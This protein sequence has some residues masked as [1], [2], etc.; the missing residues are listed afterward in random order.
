VFG[1]DYPTPDRSCVR[2]RNH[3]EDLA[4][5]HVDALRHLDNG[6]ASDTKTACSGGEALSPQDYAALFDGAIY[7]QPYDKDDFR[8]RSSGVTL[9]ALAH[10]APGDRAGRHLDRAFAG[11]TQPRRLQCPSCRPFGALPHQLDAAVAREDRRR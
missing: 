8:D 6:G 9:D 10:A 5:A 1:T 2:D 3:V 7:L 4:H 11:L